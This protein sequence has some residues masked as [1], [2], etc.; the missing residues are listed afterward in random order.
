MAMRVGDRRFAILEPARSSSGQRLYTED[1]VERV[2]AVCRLV[3]EGLTLS[4]AVT[5]V[6][7]GGNGALSAG[8]SDTFLLRQVMET[9]DQGIWVTNRGRTGFVNRKM[10]ELMGCSVDELVMRPS[11]DF[12]DPQFL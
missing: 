1:D 9:A 4:A 7:A 6:R 12:V 10:A 5:R 8:E 11:L 3:A 2:S